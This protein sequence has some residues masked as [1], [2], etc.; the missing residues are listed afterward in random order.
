M[1]V[2]YKNKYILVLL[3]VFIGYVEMKVLTSVL[4]SIFMLA[5]KNQCLH[6][7]IGMRAIISQEH[8]EKEM[9]NLNN[10][11]FRFK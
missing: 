5:D 11:T 7:I 9:S 1:I 8:L 6:W 10:V 2:M 3:N 4:R